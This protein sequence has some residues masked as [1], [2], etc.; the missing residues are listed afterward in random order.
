[1]IR[2]M[3]LRPDAKR[4][5]LVSDL[6]GDLGKYRALFA[7]LADDPPDALF[8]AGDLLPQPMM[9]L[10][11]IGSSGEDFVNRYMIPRF[12]SLRRTLS[13]RYP[14]VLMVLGNDDPRYE[15]GSILGGALEHVWHYLHLR[16]VA[17]GG[18]AVYGYN[19]IP[20]SPFRSKDWER[21]DVSRYVDPGSVSP[22]EGELTIPRSAR[23]RRNATIASDLDRLIHDDDDVREAVFLF[24]VP[25][26]QTALDTT[27]L[28]TTRFAGV[29]LDKH[30]GSIAVRRLIEA[31]HPYLTLHGHVHEA[32]SLTGTFTARIG[33]TWCLSAAHQGPEL[34]VVEFNLSDPANAVRRVIPTE[35]ARR[36]Q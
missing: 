13:D 12:H 22:E 14:V 24:H 36:R 33:S 8:L 28:H 23:E 21:Y 32:F 18:R 34:V 9:R 7:F 5:Y 16:R 19:C 17:L 31:R 30:V 4:C 20:P 1:M 10:S 29:P 35:A 25:P 2:T 15:E 27:E 6:H 26:Y 11:A 3:D